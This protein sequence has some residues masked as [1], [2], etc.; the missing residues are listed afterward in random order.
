MIVLKSVW[1]CLSLSKLF[2]HRKFSSFLALTSACFLF[3][4]NPSLWR[5]FIS[6][7]KDTLN[8]TKMESIS[9][10][11]CIWGFPLYQMCLFRPA[12]TWCSDVVSFFLFPFE[13][14][15]PIV[16]FFITYRL[17]SMYLIPVV[18]LQCCTRYSHKSTQNCVIH[19]TFWDQ[20]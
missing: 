7:S 16:E 18:C 13:V 2:A 4:P 17:N 11:T 1:G 3:E 10:S 5:C 14:Y 8:G 15:Q 19:S 6:A 12:I 9:R 20:V